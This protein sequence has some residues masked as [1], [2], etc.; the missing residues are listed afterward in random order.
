MLNL[1][2]SPE[3]TLSSSILCNLTGQ[4]LFQLHTVLILHILYPGIYAEGYIAFV[5]LSVRPSVRELA[6]AFKFFVIFLR[7]YNIQTLCKIG[8][9]FCMM[10]DNSP[11]FYYATP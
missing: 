4:Q 3:K 8:F 6:F 1:R 9:V 10:I 11:K 7:S 5:R 2:Y